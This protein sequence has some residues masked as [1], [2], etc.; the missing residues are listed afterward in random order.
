MNLSSMLDVLSP[1]LKVSQCVLESMV[2]EVR[3]QQLREQEV[4]AG[5]SQIL[6][7]TVLH[8]KSKDNLGNVVRS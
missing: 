8:D 7:Q 2:A 1:P 6:G 3:D 5:G 4:E